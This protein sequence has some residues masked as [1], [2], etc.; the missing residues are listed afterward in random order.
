MLGEIFACITLPALGGSELQHQ[1]VSFLFL[2]S[3]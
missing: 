3:E 1:S 2:D